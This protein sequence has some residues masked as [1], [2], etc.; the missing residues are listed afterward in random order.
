M[1]YQEHRAIWFST[2]L[3]VAQRFAKVGYI[4]SHPLVTCAYDFVVDTGTTLYRIQVKKA[5]Y[6]TQRMKPQGKGDRAHY[7]ITLDRHRQKSSIKHKPFGRGEFDYLCAVC[8]DDRV[9]VIPVSEL[10]SD[11]A[12][13]VTKTLRIKTLDECPNRADAKAAGERWEPY[14]NK[15]D[16]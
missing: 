10:C 12:E 3:L 7:G 14:R 2:E 1:T 8:E 6:V 4:V 11:N 16:I 9:Y 5:K 15:F 13:N